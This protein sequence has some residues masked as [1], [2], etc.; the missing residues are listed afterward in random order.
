MSGNLV[1]VD[2]GLS[3]EVKTI[4]SVGSSGGNVQLGLDTPLAN[5]YP[6]G[7]DVTQIE[8]VTYTYDGT[9]LRRNGQVLA[10]NATTFALQY[11]SHDG[12]I[13]ATPGVNVRSVMVSIVA[14]QPTHLPDSPAMSSSVTTEANMRN[15]AFR[16]KLS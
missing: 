3:A 10:D 15:L 9:L 6:I 12:T 13:S 8:V 2:S 5:A 7:P 4:T 11:V 16:F 1:L 14:A